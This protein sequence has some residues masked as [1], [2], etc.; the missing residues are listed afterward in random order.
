MGLVYYVSG[1]Q[2][3]QVPR[4]EEQGPDV[5]DDVISLSEF[6]DRL[7]PY[8]D[9]IKG[10]LTKGRVLSGIGNAYSDKILFHAGISPFRREKA[11]QARSW[12]PCI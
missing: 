10:V 5:L 6:K 4:L 12:R 11:C 7:R 9:E 3:H 8:S 2:I 1:E